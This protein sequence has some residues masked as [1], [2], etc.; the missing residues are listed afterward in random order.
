MS[1][2]E[3]IG[4]EEDRE[5]LAKQMA[6]L[7]DVYVS[8]AARGAGLGRALCTFAFERALE[9]GCIRIQLDVYER[10]PAARLYRELGFSAESAAM[11]GETLLMSKPLR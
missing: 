3:E 9:R 2:E 1:A 11:G 10:N 8:D 4:I 6:Q 7:C 5:A